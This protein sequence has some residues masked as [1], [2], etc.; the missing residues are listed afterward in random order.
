MKVQG[1]VS[2]Q[3]KRTSVWTRPGA[4]KARDRRALAGAKNS[5]LGILALSSGEW[6]LEFES[7]SVFQAR[8]SQGERE[9][10]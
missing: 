10:R 8:D 3:G 2:Q 5:L 9:K 1:F 6:E 7:L 4:L